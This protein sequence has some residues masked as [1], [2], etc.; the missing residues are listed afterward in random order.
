L[1]KI[2]L[3]PLQQPIEVVA[4][5]QSVLND[6]QSRVRE[7]AGCIGSGVTPRFRRRALSD[8]TS[9]VVLGLQSGGKI[10][11]AEGWGRL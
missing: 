5:G 4:E 6:L 9:E 7:L 3:Y 8:D 11:T 10:T 2:A 1:V